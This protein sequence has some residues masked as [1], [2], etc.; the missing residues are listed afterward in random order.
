MIGLALYFL[1]RS[2]KGLLNVYALLYY[3]IS[4]FI[5]ECRDI[6]VSCSFIYRHVSNHLQPKAPK[7]IKSSVYV[8]ATKSR[9]TAPYV[10]AT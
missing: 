6:P 3:M 4:S 9:N 1:T 7:L 5:L 2:K 8:A 10:C